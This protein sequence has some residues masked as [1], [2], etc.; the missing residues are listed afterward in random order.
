ML[1]NM[2]IKITFILTEII[3]MTNNVAIY[4]MGITPIIPVIFF[5]ILI[6]NVHYYMPFTLMF[7]EIITD[8]KW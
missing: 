6:I 4:T 7:N 8:I 1:H 5:I 2:I 3:T